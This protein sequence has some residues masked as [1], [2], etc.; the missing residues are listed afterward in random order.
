VVTKRISFRVI[1]VHRSKHH[2]KIGKKKKLLDHFFDRDSVG[3]HSTTILSAVIISL[4][5]VAGFVGALIYRIRR[6]SQMRNHRKFPAIHLTRSSVI[7]TGST[8]KNILLLWLRDN[9]QLTQ[10]VNQLK[11]QFK[12][13]NARVSITTF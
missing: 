8:R 3:N 4:V 1:I 12:G 9:S 6:R 2:C 5:L 13:L 11:D 10:Q 7:T